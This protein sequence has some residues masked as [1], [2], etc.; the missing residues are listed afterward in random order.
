MATKGQIAEQVLRVVN[1]G[2]LTD[3]SKVTM[4]EVGIL[5]EHE[6]DALIRKTIL[7]NA[8][9]G[10]HEIPNEF[11]SVHVLEMYVDKSGVYGAGGR[12]YV[13]LPQMPINLP[14]DGSIYRVCQV[15]TV[16]RGHIHL[17]SYRITAANKLY[18]AA[19]Q[20]RDF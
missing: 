15:D 19:T 1:G 9:L 2:A 4:Q 8:T 13:L 5:M 6:R 12:P 20:A 10:E 16:T 18:D 17:E 3:D 7:E 14:N 11:L